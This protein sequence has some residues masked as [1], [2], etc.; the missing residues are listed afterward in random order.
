MVA[1][2]L[3][4]E[5]GIL[6]VGWRGNL[7]CR[8]SVIWWVVSVSVHSYGDGDVDVDIHVEEWNERKAW[9]LKPSA[10][11]K[12]ELGFSDQPT[13]DWLVTSPAPR[14]ADQETFLPFGK[15]FLLDRYTFLQVAA[16]LSIKHWPESQPWEINISPSLITHQ[17][18]CYFGK[19]KKRVK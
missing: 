18:Y 16:D 12:L 19:T 3:L 7:G 17:Q 15:L 9:R 1:M 5:K 11:M 2:L 8:E 10:G 14:S 6:R 13:T 4:G